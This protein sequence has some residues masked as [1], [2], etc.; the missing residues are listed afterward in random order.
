VLGGRH[1]G[2]RL[3]GTYPEDLGLGNALDTGRGRL[4]PTT[5]VDEYF[6]ELALW[7]GVA[8]SDLSRTL[9]NIERFYTLSSEKPPLGFFN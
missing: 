3:Y 9:P 7:L 2:G 1:K 6:C 8:K 4:I 5:S